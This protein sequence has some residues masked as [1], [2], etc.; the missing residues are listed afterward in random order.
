MQKAIAA[1][2][3]KRADEPAEADQEGVEESRPEPRC[4]DEALVVRQ[5]EVP[6]LVLKGSTGAPIPKGR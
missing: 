1:P 4:A 3:T 6:G 5:R 2:R